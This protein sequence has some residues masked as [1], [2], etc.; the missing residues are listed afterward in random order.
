V[1]GSGSGL[2]SA[3]LP[4]AST[5]AVSAPAAGRARTNSDIYVHDEMDAIDSAPN[6]LA[7]A[8]DAGDAGDADETSAP[9]RPPAVSIEALSV[10]A[11][12][13]APP[14]MTGPA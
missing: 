10:A 4:A 6:P 5:P 1:Q 12:P 14:P 3:E 7:R 2:S 13:S 9:G 8:D 11:A